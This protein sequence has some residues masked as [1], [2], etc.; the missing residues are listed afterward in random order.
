MFTHHKWKFFIFILQSKRPGMQKTAGDPA[1]VYTVPKV[2][3]KTMKTRMICTDNNRTLRM[4][5][6]I[7]THQTD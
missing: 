6:S 5:C 3:E 7:Q 2:N 1:H 4:F